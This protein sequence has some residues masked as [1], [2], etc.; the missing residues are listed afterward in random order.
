MGSKMLARAK[1]G[2]ADGPRPG[3][4]MGLAVELEL[5][6]ELNDFAL[7]AVEVVLEGVGCAGRRDFHATLGCAR[8]FKTPE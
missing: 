3:Q 6:G 7:A 4:A 5:V 1:A 8:V 2:C